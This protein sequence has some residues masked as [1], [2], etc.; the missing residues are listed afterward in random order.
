MNRL[1][2]VAVP[3]APRQLQRRR[4]APRSRHRLRP[5]RKGRSSVGAL[6]GAVLWE[7]MSCDVPRQLFGG[8]PRPLRRANQLVP[9]PGGELSP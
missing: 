4:R 2:K 7:H 5:R 8:R 1:P 9:G 3:A 6:L